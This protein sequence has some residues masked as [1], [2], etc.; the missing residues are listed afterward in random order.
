MADD[1]REMKGT[2]AIRSLN[3]CIYQKKFDFNYKLV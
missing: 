1:K 3:E 2:K